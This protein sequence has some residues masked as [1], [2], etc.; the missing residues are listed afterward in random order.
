MKPMF[1][2]GALLVAVAFVQAHID[3]SFGL[4]RSTEEIL[5]VDDPA[6]L[7]RALVGFENVAA[8]LYWLRTIQYFGGKRREET[9]KNYDLLEPLLRITVTLDPSFKI[10]YSYGA[11][12]LSEPFPY[13][14]GM[15]EKGIALI[16][17]GIRE[18]PEHWRFYLDK[19]FIYYWYLQ[20]FDKAAE[21]FLEGSKVP[22]APW[23]MVTT[24]GEAF[25][26][27]GE[28]ET[29]RALW[30]TLHDTA[31]TPQQRDNAAIHLRQ[32]DALDEMDSLR[33]LVEA[34]RAE[35]GRL[36]ADFRELVSAGVLTGI[37]LDPTGAPYVLDPATGEIGT[38]SETKLGFLPSN[39]LR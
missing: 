37:P 23:W 28:Q 7:K 11:T 16:D 19:G 9:A 17:D 39:R 15:P 36:P 10:A 31:E 4:Y 13:G 20:D 35:V 18:H 34:Y 27:G 24:A 8:D 33:E 14:A 22:G 21:I 3:E 2:I 25:S 32:L 5:Y 30:K 12:F 29:A 26:K 38:S 6:V 1:A